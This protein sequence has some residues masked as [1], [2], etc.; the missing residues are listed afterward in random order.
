METEL[1]ETFYSRVL[2]F[3]DSELLTV[4]FPNVDFEPPKNT[5]NLDSDPENHYLRAYVMPVKP[6][7]ITVCGESKF[8]WLLQVS[9]VA[10]DGIGEV[11]PL[12][13]ADKLRDEIFPIYS[14]LKCKNHLF[15]VRTKPYA[16]KPIPEDGWFHTPV[17]FTVQT[18]H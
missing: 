11:R 7:E 14:E 18:F 15:Q 9:I 10:R 1:R 12:R 13:F 5:S 4:A 3:A 2:S 17:S 6:S 8:R 16:A